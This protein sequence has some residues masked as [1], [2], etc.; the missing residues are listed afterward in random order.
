MNPVIYELLQRIQHNVDT[1]HEVNQLANLL[2]KD[3]SIQPGFG[4]AGFLQVD[5]HFDNFAAVRYWI[6]QQYAK[7]D[8]GDVTENYAVI[9]DKF[10]DCVLELV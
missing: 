8:T 4:L 1:S 3:F 2:I 6:H 5:S 7:V 10:L 9:K